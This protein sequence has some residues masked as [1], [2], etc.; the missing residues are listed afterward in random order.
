VK[1]PIA[2]VSNLLTEGRGMWDFTA[3]EAVWQISAAIGRPIDV[4]LFNTARPSD[5]T[6]RRYQEEHKHP[7][8]LGHLPDSCEIVYGDFWR[9]EIARHDRRRLAHAIWAVLAR[10]LL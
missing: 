7:L 1:G 8:D 10:R 5:D 4:V 3:A 2:L 6:L 9:G